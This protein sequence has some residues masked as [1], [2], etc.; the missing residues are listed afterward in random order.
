LIPHHRQVGDRLT[1]VSDHHRHVHRDPTRV[2]P[3]PPLP[4]PGQG[5]TDR[6][7]QPGR[8]S[9]IGQQASAGV[10]DHTLPIRAHSD[11]RTCSGSLHLA[12]A[13]RDGMDKTLSKSYLP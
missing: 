4:Q 1:T 11:L 13:F 6:A 5:L 8:I 10:S 3:T 2:M 12:G 7:G 9:D